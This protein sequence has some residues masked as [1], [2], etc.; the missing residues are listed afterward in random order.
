M[1]K[2]IGD[3]WKERSWGRL[4]ISWISSS[5]QAARG[6]FGNFEQLAQMSLDLNCLDFTSIHVGATSVSVLLPL[7]AFPLILYFFSTLI[8]TQVEDHPIYF[9]VYLSL[10]LPLRYI[11]RLRRQGWLIVAELWRKTWRWSLR[12]ACQTSTPRNNGWRGCSG[13][14]RA[15]TQSLCVYLC[16]LCRVFFLV[17]LF[18]CIF[19]T[20]AISLLTLL[21][22]DFTSSWLHA[23]T[24]PPTHTNSLT[25]SHTIHFL[26]FLNVHIY[27]FSNLC[28][29][30][31]HTLLKILRDYVAN[32]EALEQVKQF[33]TRWS[34]YSSTVIRDLTLRSAARFGIK[35]PVGDWRAKPRVETLVR[36][37]ALIF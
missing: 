34:F 7:C 30:T 10:H 35:K 32:G 22:L 27:H 14:E 5:L 25:H 1:V 24:H 17:S 15:D 4:G 26:K 36:S 12:H 2:N 13:W 8:E 3:V 28:F 19:L 6:V 33:L 21:L 9:Q 29:H 23:P 11:F 31:S 18:I 20:C 16:V 37:C